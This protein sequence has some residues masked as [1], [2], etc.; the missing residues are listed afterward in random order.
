M[1]IKE[2]FCQDKAIGKLQAALAAGKL[3]HA[4]IF[5]GPGGVGKSK[6]AFEWAKLIL[7]KDKIENE[8]SFDSCGVCESCK[9]FAAGT[10]PDFNH[11]YKELIGFTKA[12]KGKKT[13][14]ELPIDV[15]R[16]FV[17]EK[18]ALKPKLAE[19]CVY[20]ISEAEKLNNASQ[21]ALLKVLEEPPGYCFIILVCTKTEK[22]LP[23]T[24]SRSQIITFGAIDE[25]KI[26][27][28]L[29]ERQVPKAEAVYW[30]RFAQG[31]LGMATKWASFSQEGTDCF[32]IKKELVCKLAG[33]QLIDALEFAGWLGAQSNQ[34]A[35]VWIKQQEDVSTSDINRQ[36]QKGLFM[37]II[38]ALND[39]MKF[40]SG[41]KESLVNSGQ[42]KEIKILA[43]KFDAESSADRIEKA[44]KT[45]SWV[46]ANVNEKLI[47]EQL[48]LNYA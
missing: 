25:E 32:E 35:K 21:N 33:C 19:S 31:S 37:M 42:L 27:A 11:I 1:S 14:V 47:F 38:A 30:A 40:N 28:E 15:L 8:G 36:V 10:H 41:A 17:I 18:V 2:I 39:A 5:A 20:V 22:L 4:Y 12:G 34:I 13:P 6:T 7:C 9:A 43:D 23:T 46:D 48:L 24:R 29:L 3:A 44:Y 16:E 45:M 26:V